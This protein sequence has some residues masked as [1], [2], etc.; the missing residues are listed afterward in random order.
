MLKSDQ[1]SIELRL[2]G[3]DE[4]VAADL[5]A[6]FS[7]FQDWNNAEMDV[8]DRYDEIKPNHKTNHSQEPL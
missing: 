5:R 1:N 6:S 7:T 2:F 3:I 8:Y 4:K